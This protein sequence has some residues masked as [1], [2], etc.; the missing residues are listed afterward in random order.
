MSTK[1]TTLKLQVIRRPTPSSKEREFNANYEYAINSTIEPDFVN[2]IY[3]QN[4]L[5]AASPIIEDVKLSNIQS[6]RW[7]RVVSC[8]KEE[9]ETRVYLGI[10]ELL[11]RRN[12]TFEGYL[13]VREIEFFIHIDVPSKTISLHH[14]LL[15][16][17]SHIQKLYP[18][19]NI[20]C[21]F[22]LR[23]YNKGIATIF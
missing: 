9:R 10:L 15:S 8:S 5:L 12:K 19:T 20:I 2:D 16:L 14:V 11:T 17:W 23:A 1:D 3:S 7:E 21:G 4:S 6:L 18:T 22:V 13:P